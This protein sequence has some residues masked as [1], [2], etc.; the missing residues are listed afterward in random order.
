MIKKTKFKDLILINNKSFKDRRGYFK[1]LL[2]EK[3][4]KKKF[5]FLVMSFSKKNVIRGLH[6]QTK[7]SQGKFISVIKGKIFDVVI[8][9]RKKSKTYGKS[10]SVVLSEK[11]SKS[12]FIPPGFAHGFCALSKENY[13][14]YSCTKYRSK[15][16][17]IG[18]K[19]NDKDLKIN[20]PIKN[21]IISNKDRKNLSFKEFKDKIK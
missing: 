6:L 14:V 12:I 2:L 8:D 4:L 10:M 13:I 7:N 18:I 1:E 15:R 17:E 16:Y 20:W 3:N 5:P 9:L 11:N 21:P 19:Y